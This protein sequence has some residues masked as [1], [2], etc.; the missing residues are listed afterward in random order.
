MLSY[1]EDNEKRYV[2][3]GNEWD[4]IGSEKEVRWPMYCEKIMQFWATRTPT[5]YTIH[6]TRI[7]CWNNWKITRMNILLERIVLLHVFLPDTGLSI[8]SYTIF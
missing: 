4:E 7:F 2:N 1:R 3:K 5:V 8:C 6:K